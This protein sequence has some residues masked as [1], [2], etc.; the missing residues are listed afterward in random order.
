MQDKN[1]KTAKCRIREGALRGNGPVAVRYGNEAVALM[2]PFLPQQNRAGA[3]RTVD[4]SCAFATL[5]TVLSKNM[6]FA[7]IAVSAFAVPDVDGINLLIAAWARQRR[8]EQRHEIIG[9]PPATDEPRPEYK[10]K[11]H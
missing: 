1:Q 6:A 7:V 2:K 9:D 11:R 4:V 5:R 8:D 3:P 10:G